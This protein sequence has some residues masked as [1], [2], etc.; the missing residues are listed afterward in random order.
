MFTVESDGGVSPLQKLACRSPLTQCFSSSFP[1]TSHFSQKWKEKDVQYHTQLA[2]RKQGSLTLFTCCRLQFIWTS[3]QSGAS[4]TL[5][6]LHLTLNC[7]FWFW[8]SEAGWSF[9]SKLS[10]HC[11][12]L[13]PC[14]ALYQA[15][16]LEQGTQLWGTFTSAKRKFCCSHFLNYLKVNGSR[17]SSSHIDWHTFGFS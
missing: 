1:P 10:V 13:S 15:R 7:R 16:S 17:G 2:M 8:R 14:S 11:A 12:C 9:Q 4:Q 5:M 3:E 6:C